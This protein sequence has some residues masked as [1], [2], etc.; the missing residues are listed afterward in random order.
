MMAT[1]A[2]NSRLLAC[3]LWCAIVFL[4][5]VLQFNIG[6]PPDGANLDAS[7]SAVLAWGIENGA[8]WG[9]D[10]VFTFGPLGFLYPGASY[11][12][13]LFTAFFAGQVALGL[14][15]SVA[16]VH[17]AREQTWAVRGAL[18]AVFVAWWLPW[19][20]PD[21]LWFLFLGASSIALVSQSARAPA[22]ASLTIAACAY[23][24]GVAVLG[25]IKFSMLPLALLWI[26]CISATLM[27]R[28]NRLG[29]G[30]LVMTYATATLALWVASGQPL[31]AA[32]AY[33]STSMEMSRGYGDAMGIVPALPVDGLGFVVMAAA[34]GWLALQAI[35][36]RKD[37]G[38]ALVF[39]LLGCIV[40]FAWRSAYTRA[41]GH[42]VILYPVAF[43]LVL[44]SLALIPTRRARLLQGGAIAG[45]VLASVIAFAL[46]PGKLSPDLWTVRGTQLPDKL[47]ILRNPAS[48][49]TF[50]EAQ[51][52]AAAEKIALPK[53]R[54]HVGTDSADILS[55][56]QGVLLLND[57]NYRP[58]PVFQGYSVYTPD[59]LRRNEAFLLGPQAP[60]W[61]LLRLQAIDGRVPMAD[62][63]LSLIAIL[64]GYRPIIEEK[65]YVLWRRSD[66]AVTPLRTPPPHEYR[67][68]ALG[69]WVDVPRR[70]ADSTRVAFVKLQSTVLGKLY[71][72]WFRGAPLAIEAQTADG[73]LLSWR[74][75]PAAAESGFI[76]SPLLL[77]NNDLLDWYSRSGSV[78]E[79]AKIRLIPMHGPHRHFF[80]RELQVAFGSV[81]VTLPPPEQMPRE[82]AA[83]TAAGF[84]PTP[85][86][87]DGMVQRLIED[88][89]PSLFMHSPAALRFVLAAGRYKV[90][91]TFGIRTAALESPGC[92]VADGVRL[93]LYARSKAGRS[94]LHARYINPFVRPAERG[95]QHIQGLIVDLAA[96]TEVELAVE[97]GLAGANTACDWAYVRDFKIRRIRVIDGR[98]PTPQGAGKT[99]PGG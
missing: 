45:V 87:R 5:F 99:V 76:L 9:R 41:D 31:D 4:I 35:W 46:F 29:A 79:V 59:L 44:A 8:V 80:R 77:D 3:L 43:F 54:A 68:I 85:S 96:E 13:P 81:P 58:R 22:S 94:L 84:V 17:A 72:F 66:V 57:L 10:L 71:A 64:K 49:R 63:A 24:A 90:D 18:L 30:L 74:L 89:Q 27:S 55:W 25:L 86:S 53:I 7:W 48:L 95:A 21:V 70:S 62:D 50:R 20:S 78:S 97:P 42:I 83:V 16:L 40:Y 65:G 23:G 73:R 37:P 82:L 93:A 39:L 51:K 2:S 56:D 28:G 36:L 69:E 33:L 98:H 47:S 26:V 67:T 60:K 11:F 6:T 14:L 1:R 52:V 32:G 75:V 15:I 91:G 92:E 19:I 61:V 38:N 12:G 34:G 88:D